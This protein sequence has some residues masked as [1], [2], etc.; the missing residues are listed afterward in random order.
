MWVCYNGSNKLASI[1]P[2]TMEVK[3]YPVPTP[4]TRIRRL[5][6]TSDDMVW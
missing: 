1:N 2:E 4:A 6:L 3:E 5:A